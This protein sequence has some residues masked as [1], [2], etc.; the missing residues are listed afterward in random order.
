MPTVETTL[1]GPKR[2]RAMTRTILDE[3]DV[4]DM[5]SSARESLIQLCRWSADERAKHDDCG[6]TA[7][8]DR[9]EF[10]PSDG[11]DSSSD[12]GVDYGMQLTLLMHRL[13]WLEQQIHADYPHSC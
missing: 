4:H 10:A 6:W 7:L 9:I 11:D 3:Y 1:H 12:C 5:L 2:Q 8:A 13:A